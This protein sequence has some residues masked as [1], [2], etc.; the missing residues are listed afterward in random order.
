M[1]SRHIAVW[2][3]HNEARVFH[4]TS[5]SFEEATI[6]SPHAHSQLHRKSG[7]D[8]GHRALE[9]SHYYHDVALSLKDAEEILIVGPATA[10]LELV[11]HLHERHADLAAKVI[12]I[13]TVDH[14]TD[15]QLASYFRNY[16]K[17]IDQLR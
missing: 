12:G 15:R 11:K 1:S 5:A 4:I 2:L 8:S 10:K 9:D 16:F 14:P 6:E 17:A 3:D 7:S 13:E